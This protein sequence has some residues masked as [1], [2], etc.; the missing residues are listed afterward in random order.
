MRLL[1]QSHGSETLENCK[2]AKACGKMLLNVEGAY[3]KKEE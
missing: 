2:A 1:S 3:E